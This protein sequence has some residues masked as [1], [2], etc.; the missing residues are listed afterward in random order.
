MLQEGEVTPVGAV[1]PLKV[2]VRLVTATNRDLVEEMRSGRFRQDLYA[3]LTKLTI[4]VPPLRARIEDVP[5]LAMS[6]GERFQGAP[7]RLSTRALIRLMLHDWPLN[8][9]ELDGV[10]TQA[11]VE[12]DGTGAIDLSPDVLLRMDEHAQLSA[13]DSAAPRSLD[14]ATVESALKRTGGNMKQAA[15]QLGKDRG[16]LYRIVKRL[17][18]DSDDYRP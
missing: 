5:L 13:A 3:R 2:D 8:V 1:K 11:V 18:L 14:R 6:L 15:A 9:R 16:Q 4:R 7:I 10:V 12:H 17:R